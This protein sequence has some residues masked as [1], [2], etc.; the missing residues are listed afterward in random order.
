MTGALLASIDLL[1]VPTPDP[2]VPAA[3]LADI[4]V[5][6]LQRAASWLAGLAAAM[7]GAASDGA[8]AVAQV[9]R[10]WSNPNPALGVT[11]LLSC[12][13]QTAAL[14]HAHSFALDAA[15]VVVQDEQ[16]NAQYD[17]AIAVTEMN[18]IWTTP[19]LGKI[20]GAVVGVGQVADAARVLAV[21][22]RL[23]DSLTARLHRAE[24]AIAALL[25]QLSVDP[26]EGPDG[27][28]AGPAA[29]LPPDPINNPARRTDAGNRAALA[30]DLHS[31]DPRRMRF[32]LSIRES[33]QHADRTG[34]PAQLAV[35]D[36]TA[37]HGQGRAA[38]AVGDLTT[39]TN[40]AVVVPGITNSPSA[41][42]GGIDL[43]ADLRSEAARQDPGEQTAVV[44]WYG[45]DMPA[46]WTKDPGPT[47]STDIHD[48]VAMGS[49]VNAESGA[50]VLA[51]DLTAIKAMAQTSARVT[52]VGFSMGATTVSEAAEFDLPVDSI[53]LLGSPGAGWDTTTAAGY[54][55]VP[56]SGVYSLSYDQ[57][58]VTLPITDQLA[59]GAL[60]NPDP[61]GVDPAAEAFGGNHIDAPT[62]EPINSG[63][64]LVPNVE[65][66]LGD[67]AHHSM[68][69]YMQGP[70]LA[71]EA[72]IVIG[73]GRSVPVKRGRK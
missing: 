42:S 20:A 57:D 5:G 64:G 52:V 4:D 32:A 21:N 46:S 36:S 29:L 28:R 48:T 9:A 11:R 37:F 23:T 26:T 12:A 62:N 73:R 31:G 70:A 39:A 14:V 54:G 58:P 33:L 50:P 16:S 49:A 18:D 43:A 45:Y 66:I 3:R 7:A 2:G 60:G 38:I 61:Y 53:V 15:R 71:A 72:A 6:A 27:L 25:Q 59:A 65:R 19:T 47:I 22:Q 63:T 24:V 55:S 17:V 10:G 41:M 40:V 44:A 35:Y 56:A 1:G 68:K 34:A 13:Q 30:A 69:N 8:P 67:P 51:A